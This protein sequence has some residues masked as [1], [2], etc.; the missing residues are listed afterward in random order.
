MIEIKE[1]LKYLQIPL[2]YLRNTV[3]EFM[4]IYMY[5]CLFYYL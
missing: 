5:L 2:S 4:C 1:N 3:A